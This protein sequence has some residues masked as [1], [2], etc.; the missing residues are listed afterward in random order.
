MIAGGLDQSRSLRSLSVR[1]LEC[2]ECLGYS[3]VLGGVRIVL[4]GHGLGDSGA[5]NGPSRRDA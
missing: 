2:F 4:A 1:L 3:G 5:R